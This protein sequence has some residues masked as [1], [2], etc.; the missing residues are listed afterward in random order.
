MGNKRGE[1]NGKAGGGAPMAEGGGG[2]SRGGRWGVSRGGKNCPPPAFL[3]FLSHWGGGERRGPLQ[4]HRWGAPGGLGRER[5]GGKGG[6][7][8]PGPRAKVWGR[9]HFSQRGRGPPLF[10]GKKQNP[11][12]GVGGN[13][14][15]SF[16]GGKKG[17]GGEGGG[18]QKT[19][20]TRWAF[21]NHPT[22]GTNG[23]GVDHPF[24]PPFPP[25]RGEF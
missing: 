21:G 7:Q 2:T 11:L 14:R 25:P 22:Q 16:R 19:N 20:P 15:L 13:P 10:F 12:T 17:L 6:N 24:H 1:K 9:P 3:A 23:E 5:V 18:P 4:T 8:R